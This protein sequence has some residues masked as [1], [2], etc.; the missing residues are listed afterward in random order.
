MLLNQVFF[1]EAKICTMPSSE[2]G[3]FYLHLWTILSNFVF[4]VMQIIYY[5]KNKNQG[6]I[7]RATLSRIT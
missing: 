1:I 3:L 2:Y 7:H 5:E 6:G 4:C